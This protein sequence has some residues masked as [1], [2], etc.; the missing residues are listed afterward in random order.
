MVKFSISSLNCRGLNKSIKRHAIFSKCLNFDVSFLQESYITANKSHIWQDDWKGKLFYSSGTNNSNGLITLLNE[1]IINNTETVFYKSEKILGISIVINKDTFFFINFYGPSVKQERQRFLNEL[2]HVTSL[3]TSNNIFLGGDLNLVLNN[4]L[5]IISG[6]RHDKNC[7]ERL[8]NLLIRKDF[9]DVW[10]ELHPEERDFT[11]ARKNPFCARRLD[12]I[13]SHCEFLP[14][15]IKSDHVCIAGSDHKLVSCH[16]STDEF[17]RGKSYWKFN[18]AL[19]HDKE[20]LNFMNNEIDLFLE[21]DIGDPIDRFEYFKIFVKTKSIEYSVKRSRENNIR[22][23]TLKDSINMINKKLTRDPNNVTLINNLFKA[24]QELEVYELEKAK[25]AMIRAKMKEVVAGEKNTHYFLGVEKGRG[26]DNTIYKLIIDEREVSDQDEILGEISKHFERLYSKDDNLTKDNISGIKHFLKDIDH[27]KVSEEDKVILDKK[28]DIDEVGKALFS[29]D[30]DASPGIDGIPSCWYKTFYLK[31]KFML[32]NC[33]ENTIERGEMGVTQRQ[34]VISM[35][36]KGKDLCKYKLKNWRPITITNCDYKILSKCIANRLHHVLGSIID[37]SQS[38]FMK[39]RSICDHI[40]LIDDI[41]NL[42]NKFNAPGMVVSLDFEKAFDSISKQIIVDSLSYFNFGQNFIKMVSTLLNNS[43]SCVQNG[44]LLT[45]WISVD[46][47]IRQGCVLSPLL[48]L[49]VL[50]IMAIKLRN[51]ESIEG[52]S[53]NHLNLNSEPVKVLQYCDDTTLILKSDTELLI[54]LNIIEEFYNI[55]GLKLNKSK[56]IAIRIGSSKNDFKETGEICWKKSNELVRILG[57]YFNAIQEA[58]DI[59]ENWSHKL[60]KIRELSIKL[61]RRK[62][63]IWGRIMLCKTFLLS[64]ISFNIQALSMPDVVITELEKI[65][66]KYIWHSQN[67]NKRVIEKIKRSVMCMVKEEG[68]AGMIKGGTQQKLFLIKWIIKLS[69]T[70][71]SLYQDSRISNIFFANFC[72]LDYLKVISCRYNEIIF[73]FYWPRFWKDAIKAWLIFK[74]NLR[75]LYDKNDQKVMDLISTS[76]K[77]IPIFLNDDIRYKSKIIF[78]AKWLR[79]GFAFLHQIMDHRENFLRFEELPQVL[80]A[81]P[82]CIF[83]YNALKNAIKN[84]GSL[85]NLIV[86]NDKI[87]KAKNV[88]LRNILEQGDHREINGR[89]FWQRKFGVDIQSNYICSQNCI[90]ET[91]LNVLQFKIY[92][93]ILPTNV[94]LKRWNLCDSENCICGE[95]D[96]LEHSLI[97]C[98]LLKDLWSSVVSTITLLLNGRTIPMTNLNKVFGYN[99]YEK[100]KLKLSKESFI[101]INNILIVAKFSINK[102]RAVKSNNYKTCFQNEWNLRKSLIFPENVD[103][104]TA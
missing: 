95:K 67:N 98:P 32:F 102:C 26:N 25:G 78:D 104:D 9:I 14:Y 55:A 72:N 28:L 58:S 82:D 16:I 33:L 71:T 87:I 77:N 97:E 100:T 57:V 48:F 40:R 21:I 19:L 50:E 22:Y 70:K 88:L 99:K 81:F 52:I 91:K 35:L 66:F 38:G 12:Y 10:R 74:H 65:C 101:S 69:S 103:S 45:Q 79:Q 5:D 29:L 17:K 20:Y 15:I 96:L 30:N 61:R 56:S 44:G 41:I 83:T 42:S 2:Y 36:H 60:E 80:R 92:H 24:K 53:F 6:D 1:N 37:V 4:D 43:E 3:C 39:G 18:S 51:S 68:G 47:G 31:I 49:I 85:F 89:I 11:W 59:K 13:F 90:K 63:S 7:I 23:T 86:I 94:L 34:G 62:V 73:P 76:K 46:R 75:I 93:K 84:P 27:N 64:Q 54:A 8:R